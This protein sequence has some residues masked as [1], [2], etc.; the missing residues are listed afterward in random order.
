M[1]EDIRNNLEKDRTQKIYILRIVYTRAYR[2]DQCGHCHKLIKRD[3]R[4][5]P[6]GWVSVTK[7]KERINIKHKHKKKE[8]TNV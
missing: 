4:V 7:Q 1:Q 3:I 6:S 5:E 8:S 2:N